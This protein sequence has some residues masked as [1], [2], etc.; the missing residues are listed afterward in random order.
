[1]RDLTDDAPIRRMSVARGRLEGFPM[2]SQSGADLGQA[3]V[4]AEHA[5]KR[6]DDIPGVH[7]LHPTHVETLV[8]A[9]DNGLT[10][11]VTVQGFAR[12]DLD[13]HAMAGVCSALL[14]LRH[15]LNAPQARLVDVHLVQNVA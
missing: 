12:M 13:S 4:A 6:A 7:G 11:T 3:E 8:T 5:V 2:D 1:M 10:V 14:C 15:A 9:E